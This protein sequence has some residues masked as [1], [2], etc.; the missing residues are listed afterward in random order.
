[1]IE[2]QQLEEELSLERFSRYLVWSA[3]D[4]DRALELYGLNTRLS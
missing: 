3:G 2:G 1:V 4:R